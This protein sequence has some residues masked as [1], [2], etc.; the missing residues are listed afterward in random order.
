MVKISAI[1]AMD[2]N[3]LI[4][5]NNR[6]PWHLPADLRHF[7]ALTTSHPIIMG[8]KTYESIGK[9]LPNRTNIILTHRA[10]FEAAGCQVIAALSQ[11]WL[12]GEFPNQEVFIIGGAQVFE[13]TLPLIECIYLTVIHHRFQGD[14]FFPA[15]N[16]NEWQTLEESTHEKDQENPYAYTFKTLARRE[17]PSR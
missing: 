9:P 3:R 1:V 16:E 15:L 7:K 5:A 11:T 17:L 6:L 12:K 14:T 13:Q 4:G 8:R 10:D 2:E